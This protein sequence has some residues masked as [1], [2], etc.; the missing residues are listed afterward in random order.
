MKKYKIQN[1]SPKI[2][3]ACEVKEY[4]RCN[5]SYRRVHRVATVAFWRTFDHEGKIS[6]GW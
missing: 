5:R 2:S 6:P 1:R 3:H 4:S